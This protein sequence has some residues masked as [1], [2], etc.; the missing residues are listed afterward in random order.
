[1]PGSESNELNKLKNLHKNKIKEISSNGKDGKLY[2][3]EELSST[4]KLS[5]EGSQQ[6]PE[7]TENGKSFIPYITAD[8]KIPEFTLVVLILG[9]IQALIFG[10]ADAYLGLKIGMTVG[11]SIPAAVISMGIL[12]GILRRGT[13][14]ENNLVQ[15]MASV[16]ESLAAGVI[17]TVPALY[18]LADEA[19]KGGKAL[20]LAIDPWSVFI[21]AS[22]G[23]MMGILLMIPLRRFLIVQE[24]GKLRYPEGTACAEVLIAGDQGGAPA[25]T[26]FSAIGVAAIYRFLMNGLNLWKEI[27]VWR[28]PAFGTAL[29]FDML[30]SLLA[31]GFIIGLR[32]S[33]IM[34]SG[35]LLGW[36]VIIPSIYFLGQNITGVIPPAL[37]PM[38]QLIHEPELLHKFYLRYIGV[39][40]VAC[41]GLISLVKNLPTMY[42]SFAAS[43]KGLIQTKSS[44]GDSSG[45]N[46]VSKDGSRI[47]SA[48]QEEPRTSQDIPFVMVIAGIALLFLVMGLMKGINPS[49]F[50]GAG[51]A[52]FFAFFFVTIASRIVG[53]VGTTSMPLSGMTIGALLATCLIFKSLGWMGTEGVVAALVVGVVVCIA[54]SMSGDLSQDLKIG[55]LVGATPKW[56]QI[57]QLISVIG[58][59]LM[60]SFIT[61]RLFVPDIIAHKLSA[62]QAN[63]MH[64]LTKG[65]FEGSLPWSLVIIGAGIAF[66]VELMNIPALPFAIG[67]YLPLE[68]NTPILIGGLMAWGVTKVLPQKEHKVANERGLLVA[69]GLVAGDALVGVGLAALLAK[70]IHLE[71]KLFPGTGHPA[72]FDFNWVTVA[73]FALMAWYL[74]SRVVCKTSSSKASSKK[75]SLD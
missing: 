58:A 2:K 15:N 55:F 46:E 51:A 39:G 45:S 36:F 54:I 40:A 37:V 38:P 71:D 50:I 48:I 23:G 6:G 47:Q 22:L 42:S 60:V 63:L 19:E 64:V 34:V 14:L 53:I 33:A 35:S 20:S 32:T 12:R 66:V 59:S 21:L 8:K 67:L 62:P 61:V 57:T 10:I 5:G 74:W 29:S 18:L 9:L 17:F 27:P 25:K 16:G 73:M 52:L 26:V 1:M 30:P 3:I 4:E 28:I 41:A 43:M 56:V 7:N 44:S 31:V 69:S 65:V 68:L 13:I 24:H 75:Q 72:W 11:A 49:G 70:G